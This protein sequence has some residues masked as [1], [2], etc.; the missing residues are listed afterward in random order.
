MYDDLFNLM[1]NKPVLDEK[2]LEE[3]DHIIV[4]YVNDTTNIIS[5]KNPSFLQDYIIY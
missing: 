5:A 1:T 4:Q 2:I 3:I